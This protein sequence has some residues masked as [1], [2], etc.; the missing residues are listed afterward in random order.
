MIN[1]LHCFD[2]YPALFV[3]STVLLVVT[4]KKLDTKKNI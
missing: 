2:M 3:S 4:R 1:N